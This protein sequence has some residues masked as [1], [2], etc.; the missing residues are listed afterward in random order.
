MT[1]DRGPGT[2][3]VGAEAGRPMA[4]AWPARWRTLRQ[5]GLRLLVQLEGLSNAPP[6]PA[7]PIDV[8]RLAGPIRYGALELACLHE[9]GHVAAAFAARAR[10][11]RADIDLGAGAPGGRTRALHTPEQRPTIS[12]GGFAVELQLWRDGRLKWFD[13]SGLSEAEMRR[14]AA[15]SAQDDR[16]MHFGGDMRLPDGRWPAA[17]DDRFFQAADELRAR[18]DFGLVRRVARG[19]F[20]KLSLREREIALL[21]VTPLFAAGRPPSAAPAAGATGGSSGQATLPE[22]AAP[23]DAVSAAP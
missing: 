9:A 8:G 3:D 5:A 2:A 4:G 7:E 6:L 15:R 16:A 20:T 14:G 12:L 10:V 19:L 22:P 21:A 11:L 13:G 1:P 17:M 23:Q 18:L